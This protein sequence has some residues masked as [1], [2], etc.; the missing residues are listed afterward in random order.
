MHGSTGVRAC[1]RDAHVVWYRR[2]LPWP[3]AVRHACGARNG[4][5]LG[6]LVQDVRIYATPANTPSSVLRVRFHIIR[7]LE[8]MHD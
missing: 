8:T 4:Q 2:V 7:N 5:E 3:G 1:Y 6:L